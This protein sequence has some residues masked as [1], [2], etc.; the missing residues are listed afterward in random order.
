MLAPV[1]NEFSLPVRITTLTDGSFSS[2]RK[3]CCNYSIRGFVKK[4]SFVGGSITTVA[5][6]SLILTE[7]I[8]G[9]K[10][11]FT[12]ANLCSTILIIITFNVTT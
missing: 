8:E 10:C 4:I 7:I 1:A 2:S 5:T 6:A 12:A 3:T 9:L 11:A